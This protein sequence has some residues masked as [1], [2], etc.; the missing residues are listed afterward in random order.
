MPLPRQ[1]VFAYASVALTSEL[2]G[3][4]W[5]LYALHFLTD[6]VGLAPLWTGLLMVVY[7]M[8]DAF[9][10]LLIGHLSDTT[11]SPRWGKR[12]GWMLGG[13]MPH[14][15]TYVLYWCVPFMNRIP[16]ELFGSIE[17]DSVRQAVLFA[18]YFLL[19]FISDAGWTAVSVTWLS[20]LGELTNEP[21]EKF[22]ANLWRS[23]FGGIGSIVSVLCIGVISQPSVELKYFNGEHLRGWVYLSVVYSVLYVASVL[24]C[25]FATLPYNVQRN[26]QNTVQTREWWK[27]F[28]RVDKLMR[29]KDVRMAVWIHV[30]TTLTVQFSLACLAYF[31]MDILGTNES[32]MA[33]VVLAALGCAVLTGVF[34]KVFFSTAEKSSILRSGIIIWSTFYFILPFLT[35]FSWRLYPAALLIGSGLGISMVIPYAM[36]GDVADYVEFETGER[37][38]GL[39]FGTLHFLNKLLLGVMLLAFQL[40]LHVT[41]FNQEE[42]NIGRGSEL[43]IRA[44]LLF[45]VVLLAFAFWANTNYSL[46]RHAMN[47]I[48]Q[49]LFVRREVPQFEMKEISKE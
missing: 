4:F 13:M 36:I 39:L 22:S 40:G 28:Q 49:V 34:I 16:V 7:R 6:D 20:L 1:A 2:M 5:G 9:N 14:A 21:Q 35:E 46:T 30:I 12:R 47:E 19:L 17:Y 45:P 41:G 10:D 27:F 15:I 11:D 25:V 37:Q 43:V 29:Y 31:F 48:S 32:M 18:W 26:A 24:W 33:T 23:I 38:D 44:G 42:T 3:T 8:W